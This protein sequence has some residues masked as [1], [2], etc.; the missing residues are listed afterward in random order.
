MIEMLEAAGF[1]NVE[2]K[3]V[4]REQKSPHFQTMLVLG[5]KL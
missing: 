5:E 2:T 3:I 1:K 4:H